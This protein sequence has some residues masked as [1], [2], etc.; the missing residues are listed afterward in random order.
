[1][2]VYFRSADAAFE[3]YQGDSMTML[4]TL[5]KTCDVVFADPPYFL[6]RGYSSRINGEWK[7]LY[8]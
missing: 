6:S 2:S 1:M 7:S 8:C 4:N 5:G 3:L